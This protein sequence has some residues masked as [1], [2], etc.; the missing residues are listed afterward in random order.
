MLAGTLG[1]GLLRAQ[2]P[3]VAPVAAPVLSVDWAAFLARQDLRWDQAPDKWETSAFL[4]NG[5]LGAAI[6]MRPNGGLGWEV[7]RSDLI[8]DGS[9]YPMGHLSLQM[10]GGF[11]STAATRLDLWNAEARGTL[12]APGG[13]IRWRSFVAAEPEVIVLELTG[14]RGEPG[15]QVLW[16]PTLA[17]PAT[18]GGR[19]AEGSAETIQPPP[20]LVTGPGTVT[21][22]QSFRDGGAFAVVLRRIASDPDRKIY[23]LAANE[24]DSAARAQ[25]EATLAVERA[26]STGL[27]GLLS[28]HRAWWHQYNRTQFISVPDARLEA[29]Y[30]IQVYKRGSALRADSPAPDAI[31]PWYRAYS[32]APLRPKGAPPRSDGVANSAERHAQRGQ[33]DLALADLQTFLDHR[34]KPNTFYAEGG[35]WLSAPLSAAAAERDLLLQTRNNRLR[36][37]PAVPAAWKS[38]C[39]DGLLMDNGWAVSGVWQ[40][41]ATAWVKLVATGGGGVRL[42]VPGWTQAF[43]RAAMRPDA[44]VTPAPNP[45]EFNV[46]LTKG[47]WVVLSGS[48]TAPL[49]DLAPVPW[50]PAAVENPFPPRPPAK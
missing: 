23:V 26:A 47:A 22:T 38:A 46:R 6:F 13:E 35:P 42:V 25:S 8:H 21:S 14:L 32:P 31:G 11:V 44:A 43:V 29:F 49:P 3:A 50:A 40:A 48:A 4:G 18:A 37:F 1:W 5:K 34:L 2:P 33:G 9:R 20:R 16:L 7:N 36:V 15:V 17:R 45:G 27:D 24:G 28:A 19:P 39:F 12:S 30:W 41:G 10:P